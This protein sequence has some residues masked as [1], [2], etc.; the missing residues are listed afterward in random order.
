MKN[1]HYHLIGIGGIGM[2]GIAQLLMRRGDK[3]SGSDVRESNAVDKLKKLG[4]QIFIGHSE[5]NIIDPDM[6][7]YSSA[8]KDDNPEVKAARQKG[9]ILIKRAEALADLMRDKKVITVTGSHGKTTTSSLA[10][11]MLLEAGLLPTI[12]VGGILKNID[13]NATFGEGEYFV[14]EADESDGTFLHYSPDYSII[15]NIDHEHLDYYKNFQNV[16]N[17]FSEFIEQTKKDGCVFCCNDDLNLKEIIKKSGKKS[18]TFGMTKDA[19]IYPEEIVLKDLTSEFDCYY[20][21]KFIARFFLSLGGRHNISNALAVIALGFE[22]GISLEIIKKTLANYKGAGRRL[23]TKFQ[24]KDY[25]LIDDYAHHPTEIK[26]TLSAVRNLRSKKVITIFQ[27]HRYSR[28]KIL[29]DEFAK[30][31][32]QADRVIIT[33]IYAASESP[34][35]GVTAELLCERIKLYACGKQVDFIHKEKIIES[36]LQDISP[37]DLVITLG[38]GDITKISDELSQALKKKFD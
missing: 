36:I 16:L 14:A 1:K 26:A 37:G 29:L 2:S 13:A 20:K 6:V 22:L 33:D 11:Y 32:D 38:A 15:T 10:S 5:S 23:E 19:D 28:T 17:A 12:A 8:I 3:V 7:I 9:I 4:A 34:L 30:S 35:E 21:N 25:L 27:P 31:F 18:I 24:N